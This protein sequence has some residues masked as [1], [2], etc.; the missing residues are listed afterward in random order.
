MN[1]VV[2]LIK[3]L[4]QKNDFEKFYR[5]HLAERLLCYRNVDM[6]VEYRVIMKL[7]RAY[8]NGYGYSNS[9]FASR[10]EGMHK[11]KFVISR[12]IIYKYKEYNFVNKCILGT[13]QPFDLNVEVINAV[14]WP[15]TYP[16]SMCRVPSIALSAFN[17]FKTF[18][19]KVEGR[20]TLKLLPQFG[21]VELDATFY[22]APRSSKRSCDG[23][24]S[25]TNN[26]CCVERKFKVMVTTYQMFVLDMFNTYDFLTYERI[27]KETMIPE[28]S[29]LNALQGL[30]QFHHLLLK[31]P[32]CREIKS[33]DRFSINEFFRI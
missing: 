5:I 11:D 17:D 1:K 29:L 12:P 22:D 27:L 25:T 32:N 18:Y 14:H 26:Q 2:F 6:K 28:K 16:K 7:K 20:K 4:Q 9:L 21:T 15:V 3:H 24:Y 10:I 19:S 33:N 30:V 13:L 8:V 31:F 23:E